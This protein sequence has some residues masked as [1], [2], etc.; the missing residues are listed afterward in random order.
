MKYADIMKPH[1]Q[2]PQDTEIDTP[3][4]PNTELFAAFAVER[5]QHALMYLAQKPVAIPLGDLAEYIALKEDSP[6][7]EWYQRILVDL[8]H[9]HLPYLCEIGLVDYE[10]ETELVELAVDRDVV[11]PFLQLTE[12]AE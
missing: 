6:S 9:Q 7:H 11:S 10:A 4:I 1:T 3:D 5:R 12:H 2:I 8:H